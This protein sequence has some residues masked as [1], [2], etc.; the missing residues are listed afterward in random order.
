[1]AS[2]ILFITGTGTSVG[3]TVLAC[4][5]VRFLR[6]RGV[7]L[8]ALK[9][10]CAGGR[11]DARALCEAAGKVLSLDESNPWHFRAAFAP[12]LAARREGKRVRLGDV[13]DYVR[14][15]SEQFD[16]L[17][18][19]GGED[20]A[21]SGFKLAFSE[22]PPV[23]LCR[24]RKAIEHADALRLERVVELAERGVLAAYARQIAHVDLT[25]IEC[26]SRCCGHDYFSWIISPNVMQRPYRS[27][28][29]LPDHI[30]ASL[31]SLLATFRPHHCVSLRSHW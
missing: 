3:K 2:R 16:I 8:A 1:M 17:V 26:I 12:V 28:S 22:Q 25:E 6:A 5:L 30:A 14:R 23:S 27:S 24:R 10:V 19:E 11:S 18:I 21:Q 4:Q 7:R 13:V 9:P 20:G 29:G 15:L 31:T